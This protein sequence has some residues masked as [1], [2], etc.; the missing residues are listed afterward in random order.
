MIKVFQINEE[1][2]DCLINDAEM[3]GNT[4][5]NKIIQIQPHTIK[6]NKFQTDKN[7]S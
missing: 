7:K 1:K 4:P 6:K 2:I 3:V 5:G